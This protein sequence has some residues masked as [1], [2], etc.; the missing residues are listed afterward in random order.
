M[1]SFALSSSLDDITASSTLFRLESVSVLGGTTGSSEAL[2]FPLES[3]LDF[4]DEVEITS[5][6]G[7][8]GLKN[9]AKVCCPFFPF[10][11]VILFFDPLEFEVIG[12]EILDDA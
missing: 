9:V 2:S 3:F 4:F 10:G 1:T 6:T 7:V 8:G 11:C 5:G 12:D